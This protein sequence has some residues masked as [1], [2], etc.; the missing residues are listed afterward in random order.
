MFKYYVYEYIDPTNNLP[1]Y[2][3][4]G[5]RN[6]YLS[7]LRETSNTTDNKRKHKYIVKL[8]SQGIHPIIRKIKENLSESAAYDLEASLILKWG[9]KGIDS[10][11]ILTNICADNRPP[12]YYGKEHHNYGRPVITMHSEETKKKISE[13]KKGVRSWHKG[14]KKST[15]FKKKISRA[16][17]G[18]TVSS[19]TRDKIRAANLGANNP[20]FGT[21]WITN[22]N[23]N[24]KIKKDDSILAGWRKGRTFKKGY[25]RVRS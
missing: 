1:F 9:R 18:K 25:T 2:I 14:R 23:E 16:N 22:G 5:V 11:G 24:M 21:I 3:G 20:N 15:K 8:L 17:K 6:R 12:H 19:I 4:K 13:S 10:G 7:H